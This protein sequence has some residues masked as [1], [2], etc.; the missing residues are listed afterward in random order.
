MYHKGSLL[1]CIS[2]LLVIILVSRCQAFTAGAGGWRSGKRSNIGKQSD[3]ILR[4][5]TICS[6]AR[7][8]CPEEPHYKDKNV[9][10]FTPWIKPKGDISSINNHQIKRHSN[11]HEKACLYAR[12]F[13][14]FGDEDREKESYIANDVDAAIQAEVERRLRMRRKRSSPH[15]FDPVNQY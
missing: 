15:S 5:E 10:G 1:L 8:Y 9:E 2:F 13:C 6:V 12:K 11:L 14:Q 4:L 3:A 7:S